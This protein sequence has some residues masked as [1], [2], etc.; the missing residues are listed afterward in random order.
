MSLFL[1][2]IAAS[3]SENV[4][5]LLHGFLESS[6]MWDGL[7]MVQLNS[8]VIALDLPGHGKSKDLPEG[9]PSIEAMAIAVEDSLA[10]LGVE[11][12][13][14]VGH[15]MG[16]YVALE[17]KRRSNKVKKVVLLN[18]N[19]WTDNEQKK[20][21]RKRVAEIV[22]G[23]KNFFL[24]E[25]IP[26]LFL[27]PARFLKQIEDLIREASE[28]SPDAIAYSSLAMANRADLCG[29][30]LRNSDHFWFIQGEGDRIVPLEMAKER[31]PPEYLGFLVI[32]GSGHMVHVERPDD[33]ML[34][35]QQ[36][37]S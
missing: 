15:S 25:A 18:S 9:K 33:L 12:Y 34:V 8:R 31:L 29:L 36:I 3:D 26:N 10:D 4:I 28:M 20:N 6:T 5:V 7:D 14:V 17:L 30:L 1:K 19:C 16:G 22:Y 11:T 32:E 21:D 13:S 37:F 35:L 27:E 24:R 23:S 2:E